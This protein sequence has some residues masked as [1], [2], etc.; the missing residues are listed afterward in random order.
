[1]V[2][3]NDNYRAGFGDER[4]ARIANELVRRTQARRDYVAPRAKLGVTIAEVQGQAP[5]LALTVTN[6]TEQVYPFSAPALGQILGSL[7]FP[8]KFADRLT[9]RGHF[10][11]VAGMASEILARE[12]TNERGE[13]KHL[14]RVL[15]DYVDGFV[16][17][18]FKAIDNQNIL[19]VCLEEAEKLGCEVWDLKLGQ[20]VFEV[21]L[22]APGLR[23]R[24][25]NLL[26]KS[27]DAHGWA[28]NL[29]KDWHNA[30]VKIGNSE[31]GHGR[32]FGDL[33]LWREACRNLAITSRAMKRV[34]LGAK[35]AEGEIDWSDETKTLEAEVISSKIRDTIK[36]AFDPIRFKA[37]I[38]SVSATTAR[39]I[40]EASAVEVVDATIKLHKIDETRRDA[41]LE[42][43]LSAGLGKTQFA[44]AQA[45][46]ATVNP[47]NAGESSDEERSALEVAGGKLLSLGNAQWQSFLKAAIT[48]KD[49]S[50]EAAQQTVSVVRS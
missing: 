14:V 42:R 25:E 31:N 38:D 27:G 4:V 3:T 22:I 7:D 37:L 30:A 6:G 20:T 15:D 13:R 1:M 46:T 33:G 34:H 8:K 44:L 50:V 32:F 21:D 10:D 43:F 19:T 45:V 9:D 24:V 49:E 23:A 26:P 39:T 18:S 11:L 28:K 40:G 29:D 17:D 48:P 35:L 41:I 47:E 5:Q 36:V 2:N 16:S 12:A